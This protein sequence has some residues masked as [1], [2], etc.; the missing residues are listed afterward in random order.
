MGV[1]G[2]ED[3]VVAEDTEEDEEE[4]AVAGGGGAFRFRG[5]FGWFGSC[6]TD[7]LTK[8]AAPY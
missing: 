8:L 4:V 5:E 1:E 2:V 3:A 7:R 6:F